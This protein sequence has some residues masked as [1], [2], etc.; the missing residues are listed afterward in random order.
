MK[1]LIVIIVLFFFFYMGC[2]ID[3]PSLKKDYIGLTEIEKNMQYRFDRCCYMQQHVK[4][5]L[6]CTDLLLENRKVN[7]MLDFKS[8]QKAGQLPKLY[9]QKGEYNMTF[10]DFYKYMK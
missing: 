2:S 3:K 1:R 9:N 7:N 10:D 4:A 8:M 6:R 5:D